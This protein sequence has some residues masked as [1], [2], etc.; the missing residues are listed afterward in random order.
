MSHR[1]FRSEKKS[2]GFRKPASQHP[3]QIYRAIKKEHRPTKNAW[4]IYIGPC[5]LSQGRTDKRKKAYKRQ[6]SWISTVEHLLG[7]LGLMVERTTP[8]KGTRNN[9]STNKVNISPPPQAQQR[10]QQQQRQKGSRRICV[11]S[12]WYVL[13][14]FLYIRLFTERLRM[15]NHHPPPSPTTTTSHHH[16]LP[17]PP[18]AYDDDD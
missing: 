9:A 3:I 16:L 2:T 10:W 7:Q 15:A 12:P 4:T 17:P 13:F 1:N 8:Q 5:F 6:K 14:Y 11:S 18:T